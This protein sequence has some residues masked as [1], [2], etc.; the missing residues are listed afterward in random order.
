MKKGSKNTERMGKVYPF[1]PTGESYY[2]RGMV[3]Y[4]R[5]QLD[6]ALKYIK[7]AHELEPEEPMIVVQIAIIETEIGEF[8]SSNDRL[9]NVL[10]T[11]D[12]SMTEIHYFMANN[13]A[14]LG[15]FQEAYKHATA[16][17]DLNEDG[18]F[19]EDA[20]DLLELMSLEEDDEEWDEDLDQDE[21]IMHQEKAGKMLAEGNFKE[22]IEL[23]E[24]VIER[25]P[26]YWSAYNNLALA[27]FYFGETDQATALLTEVL[28]RNPGNL[29]ALCNLAVFYHYQERVDE[30][31]ELMDAL[32]H[33]RPFLYEHRFKLGATFALVGRHEKAYGW[34]KS[35]VKR[36]FEGDAGFYFWLSHSAWHSGHEKVA[37]DAWK[38]VLE[39]QPEKEGHEPW[40]DQSDD[41]VLSEEMYPEER[42]FVLFKE[43]L[44]NSSLIGE[45]PP[46]YFTSVEED[47]FHLLRSAPDYT[48]QRPLFRAHEVVLLLKHSFD[49]AKEE[50]KGL[51][52]MWFHIVFYGSEEGYPFKNV[53]ALAAAVEYSWKKV[54][55]HRVSQ[56]EVAQKHGVS[57]ATMRKYINDIQNY[58][59]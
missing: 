30:L 15:L 35:L 26:D 17:L 32:E 49:A 29:H 37:A 11:L 50:N 9:K 39:E 28:N 10:N 58:L 12:P 55:A 3:M 53:P 34:L 7:R 44:L 1:N 52:Y 40:N 51:F 56:K 4:Q 57:V 18:E 43:S 13:F 21:L 59:P 2:R 27:Y 23:L 48:S 25:F 16:Y 46:A 33:V 22:A 8:A 5:G 31:D 19:V 14:H 36:G 6:K 42:L 41:T 24:E 38:R 45:E 47:Y 20:E 54:R